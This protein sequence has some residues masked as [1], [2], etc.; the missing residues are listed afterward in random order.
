M[1]FND[2]SISNVTVVVLLKHTSYFRWNTSKPGSHEDFMLSGPEGFN[3]GPTIN[4]KH[5]ITH[6]QRPAAWFS[7]SPS[8]HGQTKKAA[9]E[10]HAQQGEC[11]PWPAGAAGGSSFLTPTLTA[12]RLL[13]S[14]P[15]HRCSSGWSERPADRWNLRPA[16]W[17][18]GLVQIK[19]PHKFTVGM[20][21]V[22]GVTGDCRLLSV[23]SLPSF[24]RG[25]TF[26]LILLRKLLR[27]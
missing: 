15:N 7:L 20:Q 10:T 18:A 16:V 13:D 21:S 22:A 25:L 4:R 19:D 24:W 14:R 3:Y 11:C 5:H 17:N 12:M 27:V 9:V 23:M 2:R 26:H 8:G 6:L 1:R